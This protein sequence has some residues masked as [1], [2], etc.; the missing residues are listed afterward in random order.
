MINVEKSIN[1]SKSLNFADI[2]V[3]D[4]KT[5]KAITGTRIKKEYNKRLNRHNRSKS[6]NFI[7]NIILS[8]DLNTL[9]KWI[10]EPFSNS[11]AN[12]IKNYISQINLKKIMEDGKKEAFEIFRG[13]KLSK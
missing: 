7:F 5:D 6:V 2:E 4:I 8:S 11:S 3:D 9:V 1:I 12:E 13:K 10:K